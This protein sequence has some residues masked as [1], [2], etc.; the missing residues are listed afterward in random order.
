TPGG[1]RG[2]PT[3]SERGRIEVATAQALARTRSSVARSVRELPLAS[4]HWESRG[5]PRQRQDRAADD[6]D[7]PSEHDRAGRRGNLHGINHG[8]PA[9]RALG[10]VM[11]QED[12]GSR[13][14]DDPGG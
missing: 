5:G 6:F 10:P 8:Y 11:E 7:V 14:P 1:P 4:L 3:R 9:R 12:R 2:G 13:V